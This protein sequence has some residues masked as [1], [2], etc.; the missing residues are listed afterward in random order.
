MVNVTRQRQLV[1]CQDALAFQKIC[2]LKSLFSIL[3]SVHDLP[4]YLH[5]Q[6]AETAKS[7]PSV[8]KYVTKIEELGMKLKNDEKANVNRFLLGLTE[9]D[10][11]LTKPK[12]PKT[13]TEAATEVI[14]VNKMIHSRIHEQVDKCERPNYHQTRPRINKRRRISDSVLTRTR[15]YDQNRVIDGQNYHQVPEINDSMG[16]DQAEVYNCP[17]D[18]IHDYTD[19]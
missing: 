19:R 2:F 9:A 4:K 5:S 12:N 16:T 11:Y 1:S 7:F 14:H 6:F 15:D 13:L 10:Y 18:T 8:H 17:N 3:L